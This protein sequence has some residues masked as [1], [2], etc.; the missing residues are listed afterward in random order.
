MNAK[1]AEMLRR[2][3]ALALATRDLTWAEA[4]YFHNGE[5]AAE[6]FHDWPSDGE[7]SVIYDK[8]GK[9]LHRVIR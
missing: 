9:V 8:D 5:Y 3:D 2:L 4:S 1:K 6:P 7:I